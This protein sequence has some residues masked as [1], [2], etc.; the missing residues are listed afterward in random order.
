M[1]GVGGNFQF[2]YGSALDVTP[3]AQPGRAGR[4]KQMQ[5]LAQQQ[6]HRGDE[7]DWFSNQRED[8]GRQQQQQQQQQQP[9]RAGREKQMQRL[10]QQQPRRGDEDDWFS[11]QRGDR[12]RLQ[13]QQQPGRAGREKQV[14][15]LVQQQSRRG[16]E[17][18]WFDNQRGDHGRSQQQ[19]RPSR[20]I[21]VNY[22]SSGPVLD[23]QHYAAPP[24]PPLPHAPSPAPLPLPPA[25]IV[26]QP[27]YFE[28]AHAG[29]RSGPSRGYPSSNEISAGYQHAPLASP[30][31]SAPK[32]ELNIRGAAQ[33][34]QEQSHNKRGTGG[35]DRS[36]EGRERDRGKERSSRDGHPEWGQRTGYHNNDRRY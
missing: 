2:N 27:L 17:D 12:G 11:N 14:Q 34:R 18:D 15:R 13:Q 10:V 6:P 30:Q 29:P 16:D 28:K 32:R 9:G 8:H 4:E 36:G 24:P 33:R 3:F 31:P 26:L 23:V 19:Q 1:T 7:D 21:R 20:N 25:P 22:Q 5:R 35:G